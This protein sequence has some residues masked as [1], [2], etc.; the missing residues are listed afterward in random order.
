MLEKDVELAFI[1]RVKK[2]GGITEK[3]TSPAKR[4]VPDRL[5]TLPGGHIIFIELKAP[6]KIPSEKQALDH[7]KR[8]VLGADIRVI[9]CLEQVKVFPDEKLFETYVVYRCGT[10][11]GTAYSVDN[12]WKLIDEVGWGTCEVVS[13]T[14]YDV[15]EFIPF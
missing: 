2:L 11:F 1:K 5:V 4:S 10:Y 6:G 15:D 13:P 3:F 8:W 14:G 9:D 12:A 7:H